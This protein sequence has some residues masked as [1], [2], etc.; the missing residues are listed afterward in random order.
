MLHS[1]YPFNCGRENKDYSPL[2]PGIIYKNQKHT[3]STDHQKYLN[4]SPADNMQD[5]KRIILSHK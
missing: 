1:V 3:F 2:A 5:I 4:P